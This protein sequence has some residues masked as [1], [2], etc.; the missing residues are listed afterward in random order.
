MSIIDKKSDCYTVTISCYESWLNIIQ[1]KC[2]KH[3]SVQYSPSLIS[4]LELR[5]ACILLKF[6]WG[7]KALTES[8]FSMKS[9]SASCWK[10]SS[11]NAF[12]P[13]WNFKRIHSILIIIFKSH[14]NLI[15]IVVEFF[16]VN[17]ICVRLF[18]VGNYYAIDCLHL[19]SSWRHVQV[20]IWVSLGCETSLL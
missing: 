15:Y 9:G 10:C 2:S 6:H 12:I 5:I 4:R 14:Q 11:I 3:L 18:A 13:Q 19:T 1:Y 20:R 8:T 7:M 17:F 16:I